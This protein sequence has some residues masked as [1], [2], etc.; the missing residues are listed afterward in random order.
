MA[1]ALFDITALLEP[2][3]KGAL[4]LT[5]NRRLCNQIRLALIEHQGS[6]AIATPRVFNFSEWTELLWQRLAGTSTK[7]NQLILNDLQRQHIWSAI[8]NGDTDAVAGASAT[9]LARQANEA[10]QRLQLWQLPLASLES[11]FLDE[12]SNSAKLL[13]W[14][15]DFESQLTKAELITRESANKIILDSFSENLLDKESEIFLQSFDVIPPLHEALIQAAA[16]KVSVSLP[17]KNSKATQ[18]RTS[19]L[20]KKHEI[21]AAAAWSKKVLTENPQAKIGI[22]T[23][24]LGSLRDLIERIFCETFEPQFYSLNTPRYTLPFNISTGTPLGRTPLIHDTLLLLRLN[25]NKL[26]NEESYQLLSSP[27][28]SSIA[29]ENIIRSETLRRLKAKKQFSFTTAQIRNALEKSDTSK[30]DNS[31]EA[32]SGNALSRCL[33]EFEAFRRRNNSSCT[34]EIW[35]QRFLKQLECLNWPGPRNLDSVEYQEL[36]QWYQLLEK[37]LSLDLTR[38]T[39]SFSEAFSALEQLANSTHFQAEVKDSPI[40]ILGLLEGVGLSFTHCWVLGLDNQTWPQKLNPNPLLP[41]SLQREYQMPQSSIEKELLYAQS[42]T[43]NYLN[44]A[45]QVVLSYSN[46][47]EE[48]TLLP[49][50]LIESLSE[51]PLDYFCNPNDYGL[52]KYLAELEPAKFELINCEFGP[53]YQNLSDEAIE[54]GFSILKQ[55]AHCPFN[56]F[57]TYRLGTEQVEAP[58][59]GLSAADKGNILHGILANLW[60][61]LKDSSALNSIAEDSLLNLINEAIETVFTEKYTNNSE[62]LDRHYY[63]L[64]RKRFERLSIEWLNLEKNRKDFHVVG[65]EKE[66][67]VNFGGLPL[68]LRIDRIDQFPNGDQ[69]LID[70]KTGNVTKA[71]WSGDRPDEPQLPL[72]AVALDDQVKGIAFAIIKTKAVDFFGL[73]E[74]SEDQADK[75]LVAPLKAGFGENWQQTL[76]EFNRTLLNLSKEFTSGTCTVDFK[77]NQFNS[78]DIKLNALNRIAEIDFI[79]QWERES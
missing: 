59:L 69:L 25:Q 39:W 56:A 18:L 2:L 62:F 21:R 63:E 8:I 46:D 53:K 27:F 34:I 50:P 17:L 43:S 19:A 65:I 77:K 73:M 28:I 72:Y 78:F 61:T 49:S 75:K 36:T 74:T 35:V 38:K 70:Y 58:A 68:K 7:T 29:D 32:R 66:L 48:A 44:C 40:Q 52:A 3:N 55:Q 30:L 24:N 14:A 9:A 13:N 37:F 47:D 42:L 67:N 22:V 4:V 23:P 5:P 31:D 54:G 16:K 12:K 11:Q 45:H 6:S 51:T 64:E 71:S 10:H 57:A 26:T 20:D 15:S 33:F 60:Q 79:N 1:K 76:D 41:L